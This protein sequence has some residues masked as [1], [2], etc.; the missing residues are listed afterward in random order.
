MQCFKTSFILFGLAFVL[1][2]IPELCS[3]VGEDGTLYKADK[4]Y[5]MEGEPLS[6]GQVLVVDGKIKSVGKAIDLTGT[7]PTVIELGA[8]SVL[9]PGL[10]DP[11]S[12]TGLGEDGSDESTREITPNFKTI[13]SVDWDKPAL[14]RQLEQGT[15]TM[16]VCPGTQNVFSG[17]AA[18]V[19]TAE[20]GTSILNEDGPLL[21]TLCSDPTSQNRSRSRPDTIFVRQPTNRMGVVWILRKTFDKA[22]RSESPDALVTI[23]ESLE[24][25]R[26]LMVVSRMSHDLTE[27][28]PGAPAL[29]NDTDITTS[30]ARLSSAVDAFA[31]TQ[32]PLQPH[33]AFGSLDKS[34]YELAHAMHLANHFSAIDA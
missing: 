2:V 22:K 17:I 28:I 7:S 32:Q 27:Q 5:T 31:S 24:G 1:V 14:R 3:A 13:D 12:Q 6:P 16:C 18:I 10:V 20:H 33:F 30:L 15:T 26:S 11:Y 34:E 8:G 29:E 19:K 9:M 21:A 4:V 23:K 25:K